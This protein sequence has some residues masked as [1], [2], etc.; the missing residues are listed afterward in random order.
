M[1]SYAIDLLDSSGRVERRV[2]IV[3]IDDGEALLRAAGLDH[4]HGAIV[5]QADRRVGQVHGGVI[6]PRVRV[7]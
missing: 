6:Y 5:W 1:N 4:P 3:C 2:T 7:A